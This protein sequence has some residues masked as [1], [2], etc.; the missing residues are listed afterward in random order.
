MELVLTHDM[1]K[2]RKEPKVS[3]VDGRI[4]LNCTAIKELDSVKSIKFYREKKRLEIYGADDGEMTCR[5]VWDTDEIFDAMGWNKQY[6][7]RVAGTPARKNGVRYL[8]FDL[9][10]CEVYA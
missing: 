10:I 9:K 1:F 3:I 2:M 8:I 5:I 6:R 4:I 7:Y